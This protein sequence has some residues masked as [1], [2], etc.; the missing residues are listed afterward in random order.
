MWYLLKKIPCIIKNIRKK[1][2]F[3]LE[4]TTKAQRGSRCIT[5]LFSLTTALVVGVW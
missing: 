4:P 5:L 2:N 1:V 3:S